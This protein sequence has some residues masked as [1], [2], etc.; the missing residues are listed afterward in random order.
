MHNVPQHASNV[1]YRD[2]EYY[3]KI[4][5]KIVEEIS[6]KKVIQVET[7]NVVAIK[8]TGKKL[9]KKFSNL[10]WNVSS[11]YCIYMILEDIE[12]KKSEENNWPS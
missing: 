12:N 11:A 9:M 4:M 10:Y 5:K 1:E 7:D 3:F 6:R 8:L 2:G